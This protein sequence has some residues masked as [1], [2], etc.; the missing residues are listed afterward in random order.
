MS[1]RDGRHISAEGNPETAKLI[2]E[3]GGRAL[4]VTCDVTRSEDVQAAFTIAIET[5]GRVNSQ[6]TVKMGKRGGGLQADA[7]P[8]R[9]P[10]RRPAKPA[11]G[12]RAGPR[13]RRPIH[14]NLS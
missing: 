12:A 1:I 14:G 10:R 8:Q 7:E 6:F 2:T 11:R 4:A 13:E 5:F 9:G 3:T